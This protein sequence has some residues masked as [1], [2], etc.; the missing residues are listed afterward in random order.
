VFHSYREK[1]KTKIQKSKYDEVNDKWYVGEK[2]NTVK[3]IVGYD[4]N[5]LYLWCLG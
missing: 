1:D 2:T 3:K 5:A 4:S